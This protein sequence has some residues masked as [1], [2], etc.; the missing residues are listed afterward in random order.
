[1]AFKTSFWKPESS[2][3][4]W[5][6]AKWRWTKCEGGAICGNGRKTFGYIKFGDLYVPVQRY[7][8]W[9]KIYGKYIYVRRED[10]RVYNLSVFG[11]K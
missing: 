4:L 8:N 6:Y 7:H 10:E 1:M 3:K 5:P 9:P 11:T 2:P